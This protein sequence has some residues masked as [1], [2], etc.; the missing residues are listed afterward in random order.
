MSTHRPTRALISVSDK[1]GLLEL[2]R[3][4]HEAKIEIIASDGT[5]ETLR[6]AGVPVTQVSEIT[7]FP[8]ILGGKV[9]TLHPKIHGAILANESESVELVKLGISPIDVVISEFAAITPPKAESGS[10]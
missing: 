8:E 2:A 1:N 9:K 3:D 6:S 4:L 5:A 7:G 10:Q